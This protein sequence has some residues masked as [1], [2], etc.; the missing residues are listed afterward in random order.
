MTT[1][2]LIGPSD[3][4]NQIGA[5]PTLWLGPTRWHDWRGD[6]AGWTT[7]PADW[8]WLP[9]VEVPRPADT[10]T[11]T[12]D[13]APVALVD[14]VPTRQWTVRPWTVEELTAR[15]QADAER[16]RYETHEAILDATA[17][18][19]TDAHTDGEPWVQPTGAHN[20]VPLDITVTDGGK[21]WRSKHHANV[22][23]P[24][25]SSPW[26]EEVTDNPGPQPWALD[27]YYFIDTRVTFGGQTWRCLHEHLAL[28]G[29]EPGAPG[30]HAVWSVD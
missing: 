25:P 20:A 19:M 28:V 15:E 14:G 9:V 11:H 17:A 7:Q 18:L 4:I 29:W 24:S 5:L 1:Y 26:W 3:T 21:T 27:T 2:A 16:A 23:P 10:E 13:P 6:P 8:G 30:M 12:S 22:W